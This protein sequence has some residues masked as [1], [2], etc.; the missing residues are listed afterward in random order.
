MKYEKYLPRT[1]LGLQY[2]FQGAIA[3][4]DNELALKVGLKMKEKGWTKSWFY[5]AHVKP[6]LAKQKSMGRKK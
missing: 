3:H 6:F 2:H 5:A 1:E 4:N